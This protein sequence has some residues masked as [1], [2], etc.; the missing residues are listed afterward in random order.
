M[1]E[2]NMKIV[3]I[4]KYYNFVA[5]DVSARRKFQSK[6]EEFLYGRVSFQEDRKNDITHPHTKKCIFS[7]T[8][9]FFCL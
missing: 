5:I 6:R 8:C 9:L 2:I 3:Q 4:N 1:V 7:V